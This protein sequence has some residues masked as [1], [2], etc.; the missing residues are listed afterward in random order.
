MKREDALYCDDYELPDLYDLRI[1]ER[2]E[3]VEAYIQIAAECGGPILELGCGTGRVCIPLALQGHEV[4]GLDAAPKMLELAEQ[5]AKAQGAQSIEFYLADMRDFTLDKKFRLALIPNN[6][7]HEAIELDDK[8]RVLDCIFS[9]LMPG[10]LLVMD[11]CPPPFKRFTQPALD[12]ELIKDF[13]SEER[14]ARVRCYVSASYNPASQE[15]RG[16]MLYK[17]EYAEGRTSEIITPFR[18]VFVTPGEVRLLLDMTGFKGVTISGGF[19]GQE[20]LPQSPRMVV[21]ACKP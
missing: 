7:L 8:K 21:K 18:G 5:K 12:R 13:Y 4:V 2:G 20:L 10:G 3:D 19:D 15:G 16:E 14:K 17:L 1:G 6:A 9:S 11:F